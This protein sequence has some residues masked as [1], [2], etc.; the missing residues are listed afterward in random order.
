MAKRKSTLVL[1]M[2]FS[3]ASICFGKYSGGTG[4]PNNPYLIATAEDMNAIGA[5]TD[6]WDAHFLLVTDINLADYTGTQFN[7]IGKYI[8]WDD[9]NNKPFTGVFDGNDHKVWNF[10][11][12]STGRSGIGLFGYVTSTGQ[13]KNLRME[14]VDVNTVGGYGVGGL[15]G[16][17]DFGTITNCY[18]SGRVL[19][20][21]EEIGGLVGGNQGGTVIDCYSTVTVSGGDETGGLVGYNPEG[22]ITNCYSTGNVSGNEQIGGLVGD[23]KATITNCYCSGSVSGNVEVGGLVGGNNWEGNNWGTISNCYAMGDVSGGY[24]TGGLVGLNDGSY[25]YGTISNCYAIGSISGDS[26][27]GGLVG[28]NYGTISN[29]YATGAVDG[30]DYTGGLVGY[31][32]TPTSYTSCFWDEDINPDVNGIGN[33]TDPNVVGKPTVEMKKESTFTNVGWDFIEIWNIGENQTY[34]FLR[35][36]YAG[37]INHD[38]IV[39]FYDLAILAD[40]WLEGR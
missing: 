13:I 20:D 38:N 11:W 26:Y 35:I 22:A 24:F 32:E 29:C 6:D 14:N 25:G 36:Y 39:N 23:N 28:D 31:D 16:K 4:E 3:C 9:P 8:S 33:T 21:K 1:V 18:S 34:P 15:V 12:N 10:T 17:I 27:T 5:N 37:D 7:I 40:H 2:V 30:N 19:G